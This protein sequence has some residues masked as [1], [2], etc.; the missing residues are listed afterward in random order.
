MVAA[1]LTLQCLLELGALAALAYWGSTP[2]DS[3]SS[4]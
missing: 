3:T 2:G 1:S 4:T